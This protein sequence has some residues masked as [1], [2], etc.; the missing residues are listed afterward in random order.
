MTDDRI[1]LRGVEGFGHHGV[2]PEERERGQRFLVDVELDVDLTAAGE[3]D[4][5]AATIDYSSVASDTVAIIEG[6][7]CDLIETVATRIAQKVLEDHRVE[8]VTVTVHKPQAP[9]GVPFADV[10]VTIVRR[11]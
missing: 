7:P 10:S 3:L 4:D 2:L 11:R 8:V 5:L 1:V 6:D 9:V